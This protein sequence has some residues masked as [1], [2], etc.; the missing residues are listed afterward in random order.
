MRYALTTGAQVKMQKVNA[1][2]AAR[3]TAL[4]L[5]A[6]LVRDALLIGEEMSVPT[7]I[8]AVVPHCRSLA[9]NARE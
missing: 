2:V 9:N 6:E 1:A 8:V 5:P 3:E 7:V 4:T